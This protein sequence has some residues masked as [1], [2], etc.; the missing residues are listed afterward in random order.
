MDERREL[1]FGNRLFEAR[2]L[3][4]YKIPLIGDAKLFIDELLSILYP[5]YRKES[6]RSTNE[7]DARLTILQSKLLKMLSPVCDNPSEITALKI[8]DFFKKLPLIYEF[9]NCD[10]RSIESGDP[11]AESVDEVILA[12]PGFKA[13][14]M[15]RVAN[16]LRKLDI[17]IF[18]K[19]ISEYAHQLTGIDI[20][21]GAEI[22][23]PFCIDHGTG[24]VIG[25]TCKIGNDVKIYQSVTLG[26]ISVDKKLSNKKRH[27]TIEDNVVIY[28]GATILGGDTVVGKGSIIGGNVWLTESV[29]PNSIVYHKSE[30]K[31]KS[32]V[33][34]S[35]KEEPINFVI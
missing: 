22:G 7:L 28:S 19:L 29:E 34:K 17:P 10:A 11:A 16:Q 13:I 25:E 15:Y 21:P 18:P 3:T 4:N 32:N 23:S 27:P 24:I 31:L 5:H 20:N 33:K 26:A 2:K 9:L 8:E 1:T 14:A 6:V 35:K 30:I 12:Y